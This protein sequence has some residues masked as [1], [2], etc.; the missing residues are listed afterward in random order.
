AKALVH[1]LKRILLAI[2]HAAAYIKTRA[3]LTSISSYLRLFLKSGANEV[4]L[5]SRKE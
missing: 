4:H 2:L 5:L 1:V 3:S